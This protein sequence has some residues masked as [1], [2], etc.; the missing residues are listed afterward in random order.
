MKKYI[1]LGGTTTT[2]GMVL[3]K[4]SIIDEETYLKLKDNPEILSVTFSLE[5]FAKNKSEI[6][7]D[8]LNKIVVIQKGG[9]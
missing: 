4:R 9:K 3:K 8:G 6:K 1:Y 7:K 5:D 2:Q